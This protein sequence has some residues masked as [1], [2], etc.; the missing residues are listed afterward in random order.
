MT[1]T[2]DIAPMLV[3]LLWPYLEPLIR[4]TNSGL[5]TKA[6]EASD[7]ITKSEAMKLLNVKLSTLNT[8]CREETIR[9]S[10]P[11]PRVKLYSRTSI[12]NHMEKQ[13]V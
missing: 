3:E 4:R 12:L 8:L 2:V 1:T 11:S 5:E 6:N 13:S 9:V 10:Y 7:W